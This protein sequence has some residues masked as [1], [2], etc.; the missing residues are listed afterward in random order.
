MDAY[1]HESG[2]AHDLPPASETQRL[3]DA[4][5]N[6]PHHFCFYAFIHP[7]TFQSLHKHGRIP[8]ALLLIILATA[9]RCQEPENPLA[10]RWAD[11]SR[12]LIMDD[13]F[14]RMSALNLQALLLLV[15]YQ[16][17]RGS[18]AS[19][20]LLAA[21]ASRMAYSLHLNKEPHD[22][23]AKTSQQLPDVVIET[24]RRL[25]W[26]TFVMDTVPDA[27]GYQP[28]LPDIDP[29]TISTKLPSNDFVDGWM[30]RSPYLGDVSSPLVSLLILRK[31]ILRYSIGYHPRSGVTSDLEPPWLQTSR[32][33][34]L[35]EGMQRWEGALPAELQFTEGA[36]KQHS[37]CL[38]PFLTLHCAL[39]AAYTDLFAVGYFLKRRNQTSPDT[40]LAYCTK[41]RQK[42]ALDLLHVV[43]TTWPLLKQLIDPWVSVCAG[44]AFRILI[45]EQPTSDTAAL[46]WPEPGQHYMRV[47]FDCL[48]STAQWSQ[49]IRQLVSALEQSTV[50][51]GLSISLS[52]VPGEQSRSSQPDE[53]RP[54]SP[55]LRNLGTDAT[56]NRSLKISDTELLLPEDTLASGSGSATPRNGLVETTQRAMDDS[57]FAAQTH[58]GTHGVESIP[59]PLDPAASGLLDFWTDA[60]GQAN[61]PYFDLDMWIDPRMME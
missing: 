50:E 45:L 34:S 22:L 29:S 9:L 10:D 49:P 4:Y 6:G 38:T 19:A 15:R 20:S 18:H 58:L 16:W 8:N 23:P 33:S 30:L 25:M 61:D 32:F 21:M 31:D 14:S 7:G 47:A 59:S 17:H 36:L 56:I 28:A 26:S 57:T 48:K 5:F 1:E 60:P 37:G 42:H 13:A 46:T 44:V 3:L 40:F 39:H 55:T 54:S 24:R 51:R 53:S 2:A 11:R 35:L 41:E 43:A 27:G 12:L 52:T